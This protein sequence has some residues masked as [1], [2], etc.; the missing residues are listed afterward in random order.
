MWV[1]SIRTYMNVVHFFTAF[2][3]TQLQKKEEEKLH[4]TAETL[5]SSESF[6]HQRAE[7]EKSGI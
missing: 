2:T 1:D 4:V 3:D 7:A 6:L 5:P